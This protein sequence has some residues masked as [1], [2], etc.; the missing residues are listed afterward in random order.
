LTPDF[1]PNEEDEDGIKRGEKNKKKQKK[2][3]EYEH[4]P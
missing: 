1:L 3:L 2:E 4:S